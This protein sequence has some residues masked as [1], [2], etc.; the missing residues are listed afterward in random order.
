MLRGCVCVG[1]GVLCE[2]DGFWSGSLNEANILHIPLVLW[3]EREKKI[4]VY[5]Y[6]S[7]PRGGIERQSNTERKAIGTQKMRKSSDKVIRVIH[8]EWA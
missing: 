7:W 3:N 5:S 4:T 1:A 8:E 2:Y 6:Y